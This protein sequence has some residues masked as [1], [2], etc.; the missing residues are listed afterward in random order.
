MN[1]W[2]GRKYGEEKREY[3]GE[4]NI[5]YAHCSYLPVSVFEF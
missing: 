1:S 4:K 2:R 5:A 3:G